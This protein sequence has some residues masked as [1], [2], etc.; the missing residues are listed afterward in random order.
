MAVMG[1][2]DRNISV[3]YLVC[4]ETVDVDRIRKFIDRLRRNDIREIY[5][6]TDYKLGDC[7]FDQ[8]ETQIRKVQKIMIVLSKQSSR[9]K[10]FKRT[11]ECAVSLIMYEPLICTIVPLLLD[12]DVEMPFCLRCN[13]PFFF[14]QDD[15]GVKLMRSLYFISE[16]QA[17]TGIVKMMINLSTQKNA[18]RTSRRSELLPD[19]ASHDIKSLAMSTMRNWGIS[20]NDKCLTVD[21]NRLHN[22]ASYQRLCLTDLF[23]CFNSD[24]AI[25]VIR[26]TGV[27]KCNLRSLFENSQLYDDLVTIYTG[28]FE[29]A[30]KDK[31]YRYWYQYRRNGLVPADRAELAFKPLIDARAKYSE[32][33]PHSPEFQT[34][35]SRLNSLTQFPIKSQKVR[36]LIAEAGCFSVNHID[37]IQCYQCGACLRVWNIAAPEHSFYFEHCALREKKLEISKKISSK[38]FRDQL[39]GA[40]FDDQF[41]RFCTFTLL[42]NLNEYSIQH[43]QKF[44]EAGFYHLGTK[45]DL[46]CYSCYLGLTT[47][48][49]YRDPWEIH[50]RFSPNCKHLKTL[51]E[52]TLR[53][54]EMRKESCNNSDVL[55]PYLEV[56]IMLYK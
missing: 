41:V 55:V 46:L 12:D 3:L 25:R 35:E 34:Y 50:Y 16:E 49:E 43:L 39:V 40:S 32:G 51:N 31:H 8:L 56:E 1:Q 10:A 48:K 21:M 22:C 47:I 15:D 17:I 33:K 24:D 14:C 18:V 36:E 42:S 27:T 38:E 5:S 45:E 53:Q 52:D 13:D 9:S 2:H 23:R 7:Y 19:S 28:I 29:A 4:P 44:S 6:T 26:V 30:T 11:I 37:Y 20:I 54:Y